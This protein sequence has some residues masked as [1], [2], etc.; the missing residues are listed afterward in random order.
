MKKCTAVIMIWVLIGA[1][2]SPVTHAETIGDVKN[3]LFSEQARSVYE[4]FQTLFSKTNT[5]VDDG[6]HVRESIEKNT[7]INVTPDGGVD[8]YEKGSR[9]VTS[10]RNFFKNYLS[11]EGVN[12]VSEKL[13]QAS[14][15]LIDVAL[16][17]VLWLVDSLSSV[18]ASA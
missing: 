9:I 12:R 7:R 5:F 6:L 8:V 14:L 18:F 10:V 4:K 16:D 3:S 13:L 15:L 11:F 1:F 17:I 2:S